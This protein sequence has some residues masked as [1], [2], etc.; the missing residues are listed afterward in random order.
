VA[1]GSLFPS[2]SSV[3]CG[4]TIVALALRVADR[5]RAEARA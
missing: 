1:D 3:D 5:I 4:L 2:Q